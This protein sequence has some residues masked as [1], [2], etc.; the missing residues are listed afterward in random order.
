VQSVKNFQ[1]KKEVELAVYEGKKLA[2][3]PVDP[4]PVSSAVK[5]DY[6]IRGCPIDKREFLEI[7]KS[8]LLGNRPIQREWAVCVECRVREKACLLERGMICLGP[9]TYGGCGAVCTTN[10][11][12]CIGCRGMMD[13]A[14]TKE[15]V[16]NL[17]ARKHPKDAIRSAFSTILNT[18]IK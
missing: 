11:L 13:D 18:G 3:V 14:N 17:K 16:E 2:S 6:I 15:F 1:N 7:V 9:V 10:G 5:V 4:A 12:F 8:L